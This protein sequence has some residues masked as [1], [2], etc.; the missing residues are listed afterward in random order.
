MKQKINLL[1][2]ML[3]TGIRSIKAEE[4]IDWNGSPVST[5]DWANTIYYTSAAAEAGGALKVSLTATDGAQIQISVSSPWGT[6]TSGTCQDAVTGDYYFIFTATEA[7]NINSSKLAIQGKNITVTALSILSQSG[8]SALSG[9]STELFNT[10]T[11]ISNWD[12][13][14]ITNNLADNA[15]QSVNV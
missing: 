7:A 4:N 11:K 6:L 1:I 5:G 15:L 13:V 3:L 9:S 14:Q 12:R 10:Q 8:V 2:M